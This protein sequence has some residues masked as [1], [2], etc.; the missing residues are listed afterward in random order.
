MQLAACNTL[1]NRETRETC[2]D[3]ARAPISCVELRA[4]L[5]EAVPPSLSWIL[6]LLGFLARDVRPPLLLLLGP[7]YTGPTNLLDHD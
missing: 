3:S 7:V 5:G 6:A 1:A 2:L 4:A